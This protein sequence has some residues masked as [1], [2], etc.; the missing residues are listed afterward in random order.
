VHAERD[1]IERR[2]ADPEAVVAEHQHDPN[3]DAARDLHVR[4]LA[5]AQGRLDRASSPGEVRAALRSVVDV[6]ELGDVGDELVVAAGLRLVEPQRLTF[7]NS[8]FS[9]GVPLP[10]LDVGI[11]ETVAI[12]IYEP[13]EE[14]VPLPAARVGNP[15]K[16]SRP[17]ALPRSQAK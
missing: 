9:H 15:P 10:P 17:G 2:V 4:L 7:L 13:L 5:F 16:T 1:E 11:G 8:G 14:P 3:V 12:R 6:V